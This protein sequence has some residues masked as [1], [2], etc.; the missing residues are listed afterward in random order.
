ML[1]KKEKT[2][3]ELLREQLV[4]LIRRGNAHATFQEATQNMS[5]S[6]IGIKPFELPYSIWMLVEHIRTTQWDILN[7]SR[8]PS[9]K[10]PNW[11]DDFWPKENAPASLQLWEKSLKKY[12]HDRDVFIA[13]ILN[14]DNDLYKP[15]PYGEGQTLLREALLIAD[16]TSYHIGQIILLRRLIDDW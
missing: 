1:M 14:P 8:N 15:F 7:F 12:K 2:E 11:P 5:L 9:Y 16:H 6:N 10:Y 13:L 3:N 4:E